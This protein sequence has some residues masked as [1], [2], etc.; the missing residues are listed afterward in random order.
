MPNHKSASAAGLPGMTLAALGVVFGDIGTS[1]LYTFKTVLDATGGRPDGATILGV[2]SLI[3]WTLIAITT[4][5]YVSLAMSVDNEGEGGIMA[6]I[7]LLAARRKSRPLLVFAGLF[8]AAL[9][10]GDGAI[11][12]AISVLSA[13]EGS[14]VVAPEL[15]H[16]VV[17]AAIVILVALFAVQRHGT[18]RIGRFFGPVM[19]LWFAVIAALGVYG[20]VRHPSV[21]R[22]LDPVLGVRFLFS[23]GGTAFLLLGAIFLCVTG[24][25]ALYA[26]MGHFGR[27]P[28]RLA[29]SVVVFPALVL[30]YAGQA[31]IVL[32]GAP[33]EG[34]TFFH[35]CP[36]AFQAPLVVLSTVATI[37]ASQ[38][39]LTGAFSMT[40]QAVQLGWLPRLR[41]VQTSP[42]GY[43]QIYVPSV[44]W[45][46]M[47]ATLSLT[48][49][50]GNS[51]NLAAAY[52]IA[53]S[54]TMLIT[55][56][57]LFVATREIWGW[58]LGLSLA[59][60][61]ALLVLDVAFLTANMAKFLQGG[62]VPLAMGIVVYA[63]M[64]VWRAG[65]TAVRTQR[66]ELAKEVPRL[67]REIASGQYPRVPGTAVFLARSDYGRPPILLWHLLRNRSLHESVLI[68]DVT[69]APVPQVP[70]EGAITI[71]ELAPRLWLAEVR[72]GFMQRHDVPLVLERLRAQG[73]PLDL[74]DVTY[75][76][77]RD[78]IASRADGRGMPRPLRAVFAY[79]QLNAA[80]M[81]DYFH[82][83]RQ[84]V[85]EI[86]RTFMI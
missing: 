57:L 41:I 65:A 29:W 70:A 67:L 44:N 58:S 48:V 72:F 11:T 42:T 35:L 23:G 74:D 36:K 51:S 40:R 4:M 8:G 49:G 39:I 27:R 68:L 71:K 53:V 7:S 22:A 2:L 81:P 75:Y 46:L 63:M 26:D 66:N 33:T 14:I 43:G 83:P 85:V 78:R 3:I 25:E 76:L 5:K 17:L 24:A 1:P 56:M 64:L 52:G 9:I 77:G 34:S 6:L 16:H 84:H 59:A 31:A 21:L 47:I 79:L 82:L 50:F 30:N 28:I 37:I 32:D 18:D 10:Y 60:A 69:T 54:G 80:P 55:T 86:G 62:W 13:L 38:A 12:P 61:G 19:V 45:L 73:Y 15:K 20:I